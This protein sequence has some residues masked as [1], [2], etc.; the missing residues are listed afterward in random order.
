M[1]LLLTTR[2]GPTSGQIV[3]AFEYAWL[4]GWMRHAVVAFAALSLNSLLMIVLYSENTLGLGLPDK[5]APPPS[6][7]LLLRAASTSRFRLRPLP[8]ALYHY[9]CQHSQHRRPPPRRPRVGTAS[10]SS[11]PRWS[12]ARGTSTPPSPST[13]AWRWWAAPPSATTSSG[14]ASSSVPDWSGWRG[15]FCCSCR[16]SGAPRRRRSPVSQSAARTPD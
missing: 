16:S 8:S 11:S 4:T 12:T 5:C 10:P 2:S 7:C 1:N 9:H 14:P 6:P 15:F 3:Q 13:M